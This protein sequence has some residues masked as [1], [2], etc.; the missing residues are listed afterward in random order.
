M[1]PP[2]ETLLKEIKCARADEI[3]M[4]VLLVLK[5]KHII[6]IVWTSHEVRVD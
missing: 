5:K 6:K 3:A 1:Q 2:D 4:F